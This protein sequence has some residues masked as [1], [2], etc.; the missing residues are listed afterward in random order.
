MSAFPKTMYFGGA[1]FI[2]NSE[3]DMNEYLSRVTSLMQEKFG[4]RLFDSDGIEIPMQLQIG[5]IE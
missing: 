4:M 3:Q 1:E 5:E 2:I